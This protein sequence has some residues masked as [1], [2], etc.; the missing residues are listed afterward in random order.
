[1]SKYTF[2]GTASRY[3]N[4]AGQWEEANVLAC[5][6]VEFIGL[7]EFVRYNQNVNITVEFK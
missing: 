6:T 5:T 1:M 2:L 7:E 4:S 3:C